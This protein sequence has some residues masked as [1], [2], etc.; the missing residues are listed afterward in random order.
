MQRFSRPN[1]RLMLAAGL[2]SLSVPVISSAAEP[3]EPIYGHQLMTQQERREHR[4]QMRSAKSWEEREQLRREHH[5]RMRERARAK[6]IALPDPPPR[7]PSVAPGANR[8]GGAGP[9]PRPA[10]R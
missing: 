5:E 1:V 2:L 6:G 4:E 9:G 7:D 8:P 3:E 10:P